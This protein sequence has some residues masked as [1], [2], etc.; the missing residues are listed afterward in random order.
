MINVYSIEE[1]IAASD[2]LLEPQSLIVKKKNIKSK[3]IEIPPET[4]NIIVD[5]EKSILQLKKNDQNNEVPLLL[6]NEAPIKKNHE[7]KSFNY[8]VKIKPEVKDHMINELYLY[9]KKKNSKKY[10]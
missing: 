5:A 2:N 7:I 9:L 1:I 4:E 6:I 3:K 8:K 10:S